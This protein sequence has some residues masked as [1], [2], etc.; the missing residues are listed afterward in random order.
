MRRWKKLKS[1]YTQDEDHYIC[2]L[3][4]KQIEKGI[5]YPEDGIFYEA[6]RYIRVHI[7]SA[8]QSVFEHLINLNKKMTGLSD[9]QSNLLQLFYKRRSDKEVQQELGIGSASTIRNH[10]SMLK[11]KERQVKVFLVMMELLKEKEKQ[12]PPL[13]GC[14]RRQR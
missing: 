1:G 6:G 5:I 2:L 4:G 14:I 9:H 10:R 11:E 7:E 8:H 12:H 13:S 3:C